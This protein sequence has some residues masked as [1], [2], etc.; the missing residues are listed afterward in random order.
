M[1]E[2]SRSCLL[3]V[4]VAHAYDVVSD[5]QRYPEFLPGCDAVTVLSR[6]QDEDQVDW[7]EAK[8]TAAKAGAKYG[9]VTLNKGVLNQRI[10]VSLKSGPFQRLEGEWLFKALGDEGCRIDLQL[11][12]VASGLLAGLI[13]PIAQKAADRMVDAFSQRIG[14]AGK[15]ESG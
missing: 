2:I 4:P 12:F 6:H 7:V 14:L 11:E 9:F 5:I 3:M 10:E 1:T 15:R 8:V 13:H